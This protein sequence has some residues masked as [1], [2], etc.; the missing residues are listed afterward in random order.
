[1]F[2]MTIK[3]SNTGGPR[4]SNSV[5]RIL[6]VPLSL[7][8][9]FFVSAPF[10]DRLFFYGSKSDHTILSFQA[11]IHQKQRASFLVAPREVSILRLQTY[12]ETISEAKGMQC[13][14]WFS[15]GA[16]IIPWSRQS[17]QYAWTN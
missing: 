5:I 16:C 7:G 11:Q 9:A 2:H 14:F 15:S 17:S 1:M 8:P 12:S 10:S 3:F 13:G 4:N 6:F